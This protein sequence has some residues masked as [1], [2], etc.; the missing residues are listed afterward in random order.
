M[1]KLRRIID[2]F[3]F[4]KCK[5]YVHQSEKANIKVEKYFPQRINIFKYHFYKVIMK[6]PNTPV[7]KEQRS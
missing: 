3:D 7:E 2:I 4:V 5:S 1:E 6:K